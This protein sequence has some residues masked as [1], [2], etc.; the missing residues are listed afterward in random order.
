ML[1]VVSFKQLIYIGSAILIV[2]TAYIYK[3]YN[4]LEVGFFP[5]CPFY[6]LTGFF[7]PGCG[8]QRALHHL[9]NGNILLAFEKNAL[10]LIALPYVGFGAFLDIKNNYNNKLIQIRKTFYGTLAI[11]VVFSIIIIFW[12]VRNLF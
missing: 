4:P 7:C 10:F 2:S 5:K 11:W 12:I 9:L 3:T 8:S 1:P 6:T